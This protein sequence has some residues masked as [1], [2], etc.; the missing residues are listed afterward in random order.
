[1]TCPRKCLNFNV[2]QLSNSRKLG[3][4]NAVSP[5]WIATRPDAQSVAVVSDALYPWHKG[6]KEVRYL[7]LL[8]RL[9][10]YDMDVVVYSMKWWDRAPDVVTFSRGSLTYKSICPRVAMYKGTRRTFSQALLFAV[11]TLRL[12]TQNF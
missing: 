11:S 7:R 8:S 10:D 6:G 3:S 9:P 12:L 2:E 5:L 4:Y 1:M